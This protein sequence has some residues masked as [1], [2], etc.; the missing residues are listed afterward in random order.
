[1][2]AKTPIGWRTLTQSIPV[3]IYELSESP[4][5]ADHTRAWAAAFVL[6]MFIM[7]ASLGARWLATRSKRRLSTSR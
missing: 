2:I 4:D 3:A 6:L 5:P 7:V 1:M